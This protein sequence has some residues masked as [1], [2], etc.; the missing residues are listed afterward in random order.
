MGYFGEQIFWLEQVLICKF[1][2][3]MV[4]FL[5]QFEFKEIDC[6]LEVF[7]DHVCRVFRFMIYDLV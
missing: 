2:M 7:D 1:I 6:S 4:N 5:Y 3:I